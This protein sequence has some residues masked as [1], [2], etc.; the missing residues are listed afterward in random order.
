MGADVAILASWN[1]LGLH[2]KPDRPQFQIP[3]PLCIVFAQE[4][5]IAP[6]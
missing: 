5:G 4:T 2:K 6:R 3:R 1:R